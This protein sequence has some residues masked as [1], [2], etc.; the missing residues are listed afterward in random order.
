MA[1]TGEAVRVE[2]EG[3]PDRERRLSE[4]AFPVLRAL[5]GEDGGPPPVAVGVLPFDRD[6]PGALSVPSVAVQRRRSGE[7]WLLALGDEADQW[8]TEPWGP[9]QAE[10]AFG[11]LRLRH[12]PPPE[13]YAASVSEAVRRIRA[14]SLRKVVLARSMVADAGRPLDPRALLWRLR[15]VDADC[16]AFAAQVGPE[17]TLVGASP[18]LLV[19][20]RGLEVRAAPLAGSA[21]RAGTPEEDAAAARGLLDSDKDREEHAYVARAVAEG[22]APFCRRLDHPPEPSLLGTASVWHLVTPFRGVLRPPVPSVLELVGALHPTPAVCGTPREAAAAAISALEHIHRGGYAGPVGWMDAR[23]DGEW[24]IALRC[25]E[26]AGSVARLFAGAG[27][28]AGS[29][30]ELEVN[31]TERKFRAFLESLRWG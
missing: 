2:S 31:E 19:A 7:T 12:D 10:E 8:R 15:A 27:V 22:L 14:G 11:D 29:V 5:E 26:V 3:G 17:R 1:T 9:G 6:E 28:V 18:E 16:Y 23:G 24:A 30:P 20:R 21:P 25:A 13:E 4:L